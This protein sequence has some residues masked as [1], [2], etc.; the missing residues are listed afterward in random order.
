MTKFLWDEKKL[1]VN[2]NSDVESIEVP[3]ICKYYKDKKEFE[4]FILS[5]DNKL[6]YAHKGLKKID[7]KATKIKKIEKDSFRNC[8]FLEE[9][10]FPIGLQE[11]GESAF[12]GCTSLKVLEIPDSVI[13][14][15]KNAFRGVDC[16]VYNGLAHSDDG[17]H[18]G[19]KSLRKNNNSAVQDWNKTDDIEDDNNEQDKEE[20][21]ELLGKT[22]ETELKIELDQNEEELIIEEEK[23]N[24]V[25]ETTNK[26]EKKDRLISSSKID[27][28]NPVLDQLYAENTDLKNNIQAID[29]KLK[30]LEKENNK[31]ICELGDLKEKNKKGFNFNIDLS[32]KQKDEQIKKLQEEKN[33]LNAKLDIVNDFL[34]KHIKP[35]V[36]KT[37]S[38]ESSI[39]LISQNIYKLDADKNRFMQLATVKDKNVTEFTKEIEDLRNKNIE[40][41][42][43]ILELDEKIKESEELVRL[44]EEENKKLV[45]ENTKLKEDEK[46]NYQEREN[47][48]KLFQFKTHEAI[49]AYEYGQ[50]EILEKELQDV[51]IEKEELSRVNEQLNIELKEK[52]RTIQSATAQ[53]GT[54]TGKIQNLQEQIEL[55]KEEHNKIVEDKDSKIATLTTEKGELQGN[56][57]LIRKQLEVKG[58]ESDKLKIDIGKLTEEKENLNI[59]LASKD[60]KIK[61][62]KE[63]NKQYFSQITSFALDAQNSKANEGKLQGQLA[64]KDRQI[65]RLENEKLEQLDLIVELKTA[66]EIAVNNMER[67]DKTCK[68]IEAEI[69]I[70]TRQKN[71]LEG[72]YSDL[73]KKYNSATSDTI[74]NKRELEKLQ[75]ELQNKE[76]EAEDAKHKLEI[77]EKEFIQKSQEYVD[78]DELSNAYNALSDS[79][80]SDWKTIFGTNDSII[81]VLLN[82]TKRSNFDAFWTNLFEK[83][84]T[85]SLSKD[86]LENS[87]KLFDIVFKF[88]KFVD[89]NF[90]R[91]ETK[92]GDRFDTNT[93][94]KSSSSKIVQNVDKV[95]LL[96]Y[97]NLNRIKQSLVC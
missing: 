54:D 22:E 72:R 57:D 12:D 19:A 93:M 15:G 79:L 89:N 18:W 21:V 74:S 26:E 46:K 38:F 50:K 68:E 76:A 1:S 91:L 10:I 65:E 25:V 44:S 96:G 86:D 64:E 95:L 2:K 27:Y 78:F 32:G 83:I 62:L 31:L 84:D 40:L 37:K 3:S 69:E 7:I 14:I 66:K 36:L 52:D 17:T 11:I 51:K 73:N 67:A 70:L 97:K 94:K 43:K 85:N 41:D 71:E 35:E 28:K 42:S 59:Q 92:S 80:K 81:S 56:L 39:Y 30:F 63:Q 8:K 6:F 20:V 61:E 45:D 47:L 29:K 4:I 16:I 9:V 53:K 87:K 5:L 77:K 88:M 90:I 34:M 23:D 55:L 13:K 75:Y 58:K 33:N 82:I 60:E 48:L 49:K 24:F